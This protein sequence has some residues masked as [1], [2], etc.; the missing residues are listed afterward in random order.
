MRISDWS[1]DVCSSDLDLWHGDCRETTGAGFLDTVIV[2]DQHHLAAARPHFLHVADG[3][4]KERARR[5]DDDDRHIFINERDGAVL[6]LAGSIAFG[7]DIDR[8]S[9]V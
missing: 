9:V 7:M 8:K 2:A 4:F 6:H 1:S 5:R 3:F